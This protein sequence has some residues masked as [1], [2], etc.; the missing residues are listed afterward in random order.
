MS[1]ESDADGDFNCED[2]DY[3]PS[4]NNSSSSSEEEIIPQKG[5][6]KLRREKSWGRNVRKLKRA[7]GK[8]YINTAGKQVP[9]RTTG[10]PCKCKWKC[11][12]QVNGDLKA[13]LISS[14]NSL[15]DKEK[16]DAHLTGLVIVNNVGRR[17]EKTGDGVPRSVSY[18]YK[19]G[20][21]L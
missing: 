3:T 11:F 17:R 15:G 9:A 10:P 6:R 5:K 19:V 12:D 4:D 7:K 20:L 2:N 8:S 18:I 14:F 16:Q 21:L 13:E 1:E